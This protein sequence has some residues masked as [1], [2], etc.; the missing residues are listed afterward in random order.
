[1]K[2]NHIP[3]TAGDVTG[4]TFS[5]NGVSYMPVAKDGMLSELFGS[6]G[7]RTGQSADADDSTVQL[8][9]GGENPAYRSVM[10]QKTPLDFKSRGVLR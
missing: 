3:A 5:A 8:P 10:T 2:G 9:P 4:C 1:M 6:Y 7:R